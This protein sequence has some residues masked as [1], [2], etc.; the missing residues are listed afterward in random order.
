L[1]KLASAEESAERTIVAE[2][3]SAILARRRRELGHVVG[4]VAGGKLGE[5]GDLARV[6]RQPSDA[7]LGLVG[8]AHRGGGGPVVGA[9]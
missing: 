2:K 4:E 8:V 9:A 1:V 5:R 7:M 6:E 3:S